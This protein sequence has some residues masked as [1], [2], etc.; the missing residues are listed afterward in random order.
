M[1]DVAPAEPSETTVATAFAADPRLAA[2]STMGGA[3]GVFF[4][5]FTPRALA[6]G[7]AA[8]WI[9]R[10]A[11]RALPTWRELALV[12]SIPVFWSLQEWAMHRWLLHARPRTLGGVRVDP[13]FAR[14][15]RAH[16]RAP[17]RLQL[18]FLPPAIFWLGY[19]ATCALAWALTPDRPHA[20]TLAASYVT[21]GLCYE[22]THYLTHTRWRPRSRYFR[23]VQRNHLR[24]HFKHEHSWYAFVW[25]YWD[26]WLGTDPDPRSIAT[27]ET[28]RD[29]FG[30][31]RLAAAVV[32]G[33]GE[34]VL[35]GKS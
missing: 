26:S 1:P 31:A 15:H 32:E 6:L 24:H 2:T 18:I 4:A 10:L 34:K 7:A 20:L 21:M 14:R 35:R 28:A 9:G 33:G 17:D 5:F 13:E 16:H 25:P 30:E 29:L 8:L 19:P 27:S 23:R 11:T 22:W 12:A 3:V